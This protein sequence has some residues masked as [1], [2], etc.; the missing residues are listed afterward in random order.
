MP[1]PADKVRGCTMD[2]LAAPYTLKQTADAV[3]RHSCREDSTYLR[4][5]IGDDCSYRDGILYAL[6]SLG[7]INSYDDY[8]YRAAKKDNPVR[9]KSGTWR[10]RRSQSHS[11]NF[12]IIALLAAKD[13]Q[14]IVHRASNE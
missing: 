11:E 4:P 2:S 14:S 13:Q 5:S 3:T 10:E 12:V 6:Y 1:V 7:D 8:S 9:I